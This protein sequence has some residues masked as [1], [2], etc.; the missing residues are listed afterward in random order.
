MKMLPLP[1]APSHQCRDAEEHVCSRHR[2]AVP[3]SLR[4]M[5]SV[6][7]HALDPSKDP[8]LKVKCSPHKV[9]VTQDYQTALCV[10]RKHLLPRQKKGN[11]AHK[12]WVGPSNL[13][14]CRP[15]PVALSPMVCGSDGHTYT[16]KTS[17]ACNNG[18]PGGFH[19]WL[20]RFAF[21]RVEA[22]GAFW[23][24]RSAE[25]C[26]CPSCRLRSVFVGRG[27]LATD[28]CAALVLRALMPVMLRAKLKLPS[29]KAT[30]ETNI[31]DV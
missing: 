20:L 21:G 30:N 26:L 13:V 28:M 15:C 29:A 27:L 25:R 11:V 2:I 8:C 5:R 18:R 14:K 16:S 9:C 7:A 4:K 6:Q 24:I 3:T 10:S 23:D 19:E 31:F 17:V 1:Q 12:H 22:V